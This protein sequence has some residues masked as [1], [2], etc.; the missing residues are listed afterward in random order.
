[1][2]LN[3]NN[4]VCDVTDDINT[5]ANNNFSRTWE[6]QLPSCSSATGVNLN[7]LRP[8]EAP[9][10]V[11][12][13]FPNNFRVYTDLNET[14]HSNRENTSE[15]AQNDVMEEFELR[16]LL[17]EWKLGHLAEELLCKFVI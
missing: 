7:P 14:H 8:V 16:N 10:N 13:N 11:E 3:K 4:A 17:D 15:Y 1:M 5:G 9:P 2:D 12:D 6:W